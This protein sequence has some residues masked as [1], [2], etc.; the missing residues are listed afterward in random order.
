MTYKP[1]E[2]LTE[3]LNEMQLYSYRLTDGS[4]IVAEYVDAD[5]DNGILNIASPL[6]L[7]FD[8]ITEKTYFRPWLD[9]IDEELVQLSGD[10]IIGFTETPLQLKLHYHKYFLVQKL[11][12][13]LTD[14]E[15]DKLLFGNT[16]PPV[17][18]QDLTDNDYEEGEEWK[19]DNGISNSDDLQN[20]NG[21]QSTT[22]YHIQWR[23]KH[24]DNK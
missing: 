22:D 13:V 3:F 19:I 11:Q 20:D 12:D 17:D 6:E 24:K 2:A 15:I 4:Y 1:S 18:N 14:D 8:D 9:V 10:K 16:Y 21:Y 5:D 7:S 23:K